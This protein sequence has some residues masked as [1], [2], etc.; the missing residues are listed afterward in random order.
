MKKRGFALTLALVLLLLTGCSG[1]GAQQSGKTSVRVVLALPYVADGAEDALEKSIADA[2]PELNTADA[3]LNV[4]AVSTGDPEKD[5]Y[6][7]MAGVAQMGG[8]FSSKEVE[9]LICKSDDARRYGDNGEAYIPL[10]QLF[11]DA[12]LAEMGVSGTGVGMT[13]ENGNPTGETSVPCGI[14]LSG[15]K[16]LE[17][18]VTAKDL[19]VYVVQGTP[20][21]ENAKAVIRHLA[22]LK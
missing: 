14:D 13:D 17:K 1:G 3:K 8:M 4:A 18:L 20:N 7:T 22:G 11:T 19:G 16:A 9:I 5:P 15:C 2:L 21:V 12:E 10:S 6:G